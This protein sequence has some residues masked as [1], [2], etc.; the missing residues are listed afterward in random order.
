MLVVSQ[1]V[2]NIR[3]FEDESFHRP[4]AWQRVNANKFF[5]IATGAVDRY[6]AF[7]RLDQPSQRSTVVDPFL[8]LL[9]N[10]PRTVT[11]RSQF[12][13][14]VWTQMPEALPLDRIQ[15]LNTGL[16]RPGRIRRS[17]RSVGQ[18]K[19]S[20]RIAHKSAAILFCPIGELVP[21]LRIP[22]ADHR[23]GR[24]HDDEFPIGGHFK[25]Q[26]WMFR[27]QSSELVVRHRM[28]SED[29]G[30]M[31]LIDCKRHNFSVMLCSAVGEITA[32]TI[33]RMA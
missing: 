33:R 30:K 10:C 18:H 26:I 5:S 21:D 23:E 9:A 4:F 13:D 19:A 12:N 11:G 28:G 20:R 7:A 15:L 6:G 8:H 1:R 22:K 29:G 24:E 31:F 14:E 16:Q 3:Q 32:A 27:A 17:A 25:K 2:P